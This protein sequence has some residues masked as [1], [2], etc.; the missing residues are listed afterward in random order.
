M[1]EVLYHSLETGLAFVIIL[2]PFV[3]GRSPFPPQTDPIGYTAAS[4]PPLSEVLT[5]P[6]TSPP[7]C[8]PPE[9]PSFPRNARR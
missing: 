7:R 1:P 5:F 8:F 3:E 6:L 4:A 2:L 9:I